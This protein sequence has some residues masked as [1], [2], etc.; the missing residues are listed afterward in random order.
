MHSITP[1]HLPETITRGDNLLQG[2][3]NDFSQEVM[4]KLRTEDIEIISWAKIW[5]WCPRKFQEKS[6]FRRLKEELRSSSAGN[7]GECC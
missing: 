1:P 6:T 4:F 5:L 2:V 7:S 3:R